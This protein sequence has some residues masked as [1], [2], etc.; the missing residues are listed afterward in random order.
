MRL[1]NLD[2]NEKKMLHLEGYEVDGS[3]ERKKYNGKFYELVRFKGVH[4]S[5]YCIYEVQNDKCNGSAELLDN[6]VVKLR[7]RMKDGIREGK[8]IL[9]HEGMVSKEGRWSDDDQSERRM[10]L[11][12]VGGPMMI[13][14]R[15]NEIIYEGRFNE[16][17][18][19]EGRGV[20]YEKGV[21]KRSGIFRRDAL[22]HACQEF[23]DETTMIEF[24]GDETDD[25]I[26]VLRR[27]PI[28][29][30]GFTYNES[31]HVYQ[32]NGRCRLLGKR[33]GIC[34]ETE[35]G[36]K[37]V[38]GWYVARDSGESLRMAVV[39]L[40]AADGFEAF[41][42][43]P[44]SAE[45]LEIPAG[46]WKMQPA[47]SY[48]LVALP[49]LRLLKIRTQ[50]SLLCERFIV[51]SLP[52]LEEI[53]VE[54]AN[55]EMEG[56]PAETFLVAFCDKL[57]KIVIG[58]GT[59]RCYDRCELRGLRALRSVSFG[60]DSFVDTKEFLLEGGRFIGVRK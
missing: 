50:N 7:W 36:V 49:R 40:M 56:K 13:I 3:P 52:E 14:T 47:M 43:N 15:D 27:R 60:S 1:D 51:Q 11:N 58:D 31:L 42:A 30:G 54:K 21:L 16:Q 57:A 10:I 32:R 6:G 48:E 41:L 22:T 35:N 8:W 9:F 23:V 2:E 17:F 39:P 33:D 4:A 29:V 59:F 20:E 55:G 38:N 5:E 28:Y 12:K 45:E 25:N 34:S 46:R 44:S 24:E 18:E 19:R 53:V 37:L 26:D